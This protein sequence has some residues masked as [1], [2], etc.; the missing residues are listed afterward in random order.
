MADWS[1]LKQ[2]ILIPRINPPVYDLA[3]P[4]RPT[5]TSFEDC[6]ANLLNQMETLGINSRVV[7]G[8]FWS[9]TTL[10]HRE[11]VS[12]TNLAERG[13]C[14]NIAWYR[15]GR[16]LRGVVCPI[17]SPDISSVFEWSAPSSMRAECV[18]IA[19]H[20]SVA[21][22]SPATIAAVLLITR[23]R[24]VYRELES[25]LGAGAVGSEETSGDIHGISVVLN[26]AFCRHKRSIKYSN[27]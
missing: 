1:L 17:D 20:T 27:T 21:Q 19:G 25:Q 8:T 13:R 24:G 5:P 4:C 6:G 7:F 15:R 14:I 10:G 22:S 16:P 23:S 9:L 26:F 18:S 11:F 12:T 2:N 3:T